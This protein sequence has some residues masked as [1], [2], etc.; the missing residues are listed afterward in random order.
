MNNRQGFT[1]VELLVAVAIGGILV[2]VFLGYHRTGFYREYTLSAEA[3]SLIGALNTARMKAT[4]TRMFIDISECQGTTEGTFYKTWTFTGYSKIPTGFRDGDFVSFSN[5]GQVDSMTG[6]TQMNAGLNGGALRIYNVTE[7]ENSPMEYR[8]VFKSDFYVD[9]ATLGS[10]VAPP[11]YYG[12][13][14]NKRP[15]F[16]RNLTRASELIVRKKSGVDWVTSSPDVLK[17]YDKSEFFFYGD[18]SSEVRITEANDP[19]NAG[20]DDKVAVFFNSQGL[21]ALEGG[22]V[23]TLTY[24]AGAGTHA[25]TVTITPLG[26]AIVGRVVKNW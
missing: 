11:Y 1:I 15:A 26:R 21:P 9:P 10:V 22:Y 20:K 23:F 5:L 13:K 4:E 6:L 24:A 8:V 7:S 17:N 25:K 2:T 18:R 19:V 14:N 16:A 12:P 3:R